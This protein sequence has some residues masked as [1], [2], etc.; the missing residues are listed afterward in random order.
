MKEVLLSDTK[1]RIKDGVDKVANVV[2]VTLGGKGKNVILFN[3]F[4]PAQIIND[5][6]TIARE[7]ELSDSVENV[8]A[9]LAKKAAEKTNEEAGDGTTTT[10]VLLQAYLDEMMKVDS[11]DSRGMRDSIRK[12]MD[13][14]I[15]F[16]DENKRELKD[17]DI[18]KIARNSSLDDG[19]ADTIYKLIKE[20]GKDGIISIEDS[21]VSGISHEVVAGLRIDDGFI[22]PYMITDQLSQ[23]GILKDV[24][25]LLTR[26][27]LGSINDIMPFLESL[28]MN[29]INKLVI[30]CEEISDEVLGMFVINKLNGIF[31]P[32][33]IKTRNMEDIAVITGAEIA[34]EENQIKYSLDMLGEA[35][36]VEASKYG[37]TITGGKEEKEVIDEKIEELKAQLETLKTDNASPFEINSIKQ[38]IAK[39]NGG[40]S[41]IK[42]GG[43][44]EQ[45]TKEKKLK[46]EDALN[47]VRSAMD[48]GIVEGGGMILYRASKMLSLLNFPEGT[49][50]DQE[51]L[52]LVQKV[53]EKPL[54]QILINADEDRDHVYNMLT[55]GD[56]AGK[57]F[58]V[59][60]RQYENM[61]ESGI[62]DPAKV[63]KCAL[64]NSF[65]MGNQ[66]LT[67]EGAVIVKSEKE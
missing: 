17:E 42:I 3:G 44:N 28:Q 24:K 66:I 18:Q 36:S 43:D 54:E 47:A 57:G 48:E 33:I 67:A 41:V 19:I 62:I 31:Q 29:K 27:N 65:A 58:N 7:V 9:D 40:V 12:Y 60:T 5:G 30:M 21:R 45:E 64:K 56:K 55:I 61:F 37:T 15:K 26:R 32:L 14:V 49:P 2:K 50:I 46:L 1:K 16:I 51:A 23:R 4:T 13:M 25:I 39:L 52:N 11:K 20:I 22:T 59:I 63:V 38:R 34:T 6:V 35:A 53:I 8:G 10:L